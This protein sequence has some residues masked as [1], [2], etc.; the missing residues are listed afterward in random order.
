MDIELPWTTF[1]PLIDAGANFRYLNR[2]DVLVYSLFMLDG[3][4]V[5]YCNIA[6]VG[7]TDQNDF[8]QNYISKAVPQLTSL[9]INNKLAN[10]S[11]LLQNLISEVKSLK[12]AILQIGG[13]NEN[14]FDSTKF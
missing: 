4:I 3:S 5:I 2:T 1:K 8:E 12:L 13:L 9:D 14:D 7:T 10:H 11:E 6:Q